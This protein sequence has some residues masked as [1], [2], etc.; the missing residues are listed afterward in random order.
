[1]E[2]INQ[3]KKRLICY[4]DMDGVLCDYVNGWSEMKRLVEIEYPQSIHGFYRG[5]KPLTNAIQSYKTLE[6]IY[7]VRILTR[8]SYKNLHCYTEKAQ[9]VLH[10]L[11]EKAQEKMILAPDKSLLKGDILIDD[12]INA[13]QLGFEGRLI[14]F[15]H[16]PTENWT[17]IIH[18]LT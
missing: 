16:A 18:L 5:L 7:D 1:M 15:G 13:G 11:G 14:R 3:N 12:E 17:K 6:E 10:H 9:W 4:V 2:S 8:P